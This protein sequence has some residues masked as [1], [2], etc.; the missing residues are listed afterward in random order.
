[1]TRFVIIAL[2]FLC[3]CY[4][5]RRVHVL[6]TENYSD[7]KLKRQ[8]EVT[9]KTNKEFELHEN[10][11]EE[12]TVDKGY[13][14]NGKLMYEV[15]YTYHLGFDY[16]CRQALYKMSLYDSTGVKR[17]FIKSECDCHKETEITYN[18]E[19]K[20]LTKSYKEIKRLY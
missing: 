12:T 11:K 4:N 20:V 7:G 14:H 5:T 19:G 18:A 9:T 15:K 10:F 17:Y 6:R 2:F 1:M 3:S 16:P 8:F 13:F